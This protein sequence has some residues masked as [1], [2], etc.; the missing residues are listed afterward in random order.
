MARK[1]KLEDASEPLQVKKSKVTIMSN[2]QITGQLEQSHDGTGVAPRIDDKANPAPAIQEPAP[3][4][5]EILPPNLKDLLQKYSFARMSIKSNSKI[6]SKVKNLLAHM[7]RFSFAD[8]NPRPGVIVIDARASDATKMLSVIEIAKRE[9]EA[10]ERSGKWFQYSRVS[11]ELTKIPR[12]LKNA[13]NQ[14]EDDAPDRDEA[15]SD[16]KHDAVASKDP[17]TEDIDTKLRAV[18]VLTIYMTRISI[19][20]LKQEFGEQTNAPSTGK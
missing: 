5:S 7:S 8:K 3:E 19:P 18:P 1:H 17:A 9:I 6:N 16:N 2:Q 15:E 11:S 4:Y 12:Q 20:E 14:M 10:E 13:S